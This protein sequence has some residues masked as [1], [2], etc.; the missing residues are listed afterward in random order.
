MEQKYSYPDHKY[1][2]GRIILG[3]RT[4]TRLTQIELAKHLGVN[5][6]SIQNWEAGENYPKDNRLQTLIE[7]FLRLGGFGIGHERE[8][9]QHLWD[10]VSQDAPQKLGFFDGLWFDN[11]LA[12][13]KPVSATSQPG[14]TIPAASPHPIWGFTLPY[15]D[16]GEALD[17]QG[18]VGREE[19]QATLIKWVTQERSRLIAILG[20]GG[21]G[22][23]CLTVTVARSLASQFD[24]VVFRSLQTAPSLDETLDNLLG[25]QANLGT[26]HLPATQAEKISLLLD[27]VRHQ[28]CLLILDNLEAIMQEGLGAGQYRE[29]YASYGLLFERLA[30]T[31]HQSCV[32][33]TSREKPF[34]LGI[35]EVRTGPVRVLALGGLNYEASR[36]LLAQAELRGG[37]LDW[38]NLIRRYNGHPLALKLVSEPI[39]E[40]F[41]GSIHAFL[42]SATALFGGLLYLLDQHY[43]RLSELERYLLVHLAAEPAAGE[44]NRLGEP[45]TLHEEPN[46]LLEGLEALRRRYLVERAKGSQIFS[47]QPV[48]REYALQYCG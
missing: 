41:D 6:R 11:L 12:E 39:R 35:A 32:L 42:T 44:I 14:L 28:R 7:T 46:K 24:Y 3:L 23:T 43:N 37:T 33:V 17:S 20:M 19:E 48:V 16:W 31:A 25:F 1:E 47:L 45:R 15:Q 36:V 9:A 13:I 30:E 21:I 34:Q 10:Q 4:R 5:I 18:F 26:T 38:L 22:K 2:V 29:G 27:L 40:L 8:E